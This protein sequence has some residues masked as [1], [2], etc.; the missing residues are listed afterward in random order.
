[1]LVARV[2]PTE[3]T[4]MIPM[5]GVFTADDAWMLTGDL[6]R[7]DADGDYW[8]VDNAGDVI[9]SADGPVFTGPIR[10]ALGDLPAVDLVVAYGISPPGAEHEVAIAAVTVR[11]ARELAGKDL[12]SAL[13]GLDRGRRPAIVHVVKEIPVTTWFRPV[14]APL[15]AA[16]IPQPGPGIKAWYLDGSGD[17]YRPLTEAAHRRIVRRAA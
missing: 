8:R 9:H 7:R 2:R 17:A 1:M 15:R 6:F 3:P 13:R 4:T 5:R 10:D 14:T 12:G 16:G 11:P